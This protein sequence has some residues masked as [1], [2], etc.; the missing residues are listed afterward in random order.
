MRYDGGSSGAK[1]HDDDHF[2]YIQHLLYRT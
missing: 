2:N 1:G